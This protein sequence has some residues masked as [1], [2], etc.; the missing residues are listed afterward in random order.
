MDR[1][2]TIFGLGCLA[3]LAV[4]A[5]ALADQSRKVWRIGVLSIRSRP[6][7][8]DDDYQYGPFLKGLR[9]LGYIEG[10]NLL[11]EWR[12]AHGDYKLLPGLADEL[13]RLNVDVLAVINVPVIRAAQQATKTIPIVMLTAS[14][15]VSSGFVASLSHPGG[16]ITGLSNINVD[17]SAKYI[18][19][20]STLIPNLTRIVYLLNPENSNNKLALKNL[21]SAAARRAI[22]VVAVPVGHSIDDTFTLIAKHKP[23][24]IIVGLD[25]RFGEAR[26]QIADLAIK[27]RIPSLFPQRDF[28]QAGGLM[29]YG[30]NFAENYRYAATYIDRI[31]RGAK[32]HELP[33]ETAAKLELVINLKT[34]KS[35]GLTVPGELVARANDL[36]Q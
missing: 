23:Q 17:L 2:R 31:L 19:L 13:V 34:A 15:P 9:Q 20:V 29:S 25:S 35:L 12:F 14:D 32:P 33:V 28:T 26:Y 30:E 16:N 10:K 7:S 1:R 8:F 3:G 6:V 27:R 22:R 18:E 21:E 4:C 11:I 36:I 5:Y 24:A